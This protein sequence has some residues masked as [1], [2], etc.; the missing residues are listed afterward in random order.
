MVA[1]LIIII[2]IIIIVLFYISSFLTFSI[3]N[4]CTSMDQRKINE[5]SDF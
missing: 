5:W 1:C 3:S 4:G 2:I